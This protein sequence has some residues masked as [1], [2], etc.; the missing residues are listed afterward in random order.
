MKN[1]FDQISKKLER[2]FKMKSKKISPN[3]ILTPR[4]NYGIINEEP[5][6]LPKINT[7]E[8]VSLVIYYH[9]QK[10]IDYFQ[11]LRSSG[12]DPYTKKLELGWKT[13]YYGISAQNESV[14]KRYR[15]MFEHIG[16]SN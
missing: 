1:R 4:Y 11:S 9:I 6:T 16:E 2:V 5:I 13:H 10:N 14:Y 12:Y 3:K 15:I 7:K 8:P